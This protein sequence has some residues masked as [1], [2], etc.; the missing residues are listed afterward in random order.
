[1]NFSA[2]ISG[3]LAVAAFIAAIGDSVAF[4]ASE[5]GK[6]VGMISS[7]GFYYGVDGEILLID[8][9]FS[10]L[11]QAGKFDA[12]VA[13]T[14]LASDVIL[15]G[16]HDFAK[17]LPGSDYRT[18]TRIAWSFELYRAVGSYEGVSDTLNTKLDDLDNATNEEV[19]ATAFECENKL[20][21]A[22]SG[23]HPAVRAANA[24]S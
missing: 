11:P 8:S 20:K 9:M 4:A 13:A 10:E 23:E 15:N 14:C 2:F 12:E 3:I 17:G 21:E 5:N 1:M 19:S 16:V 18:A 22:Y 24:K 7:L 6:S